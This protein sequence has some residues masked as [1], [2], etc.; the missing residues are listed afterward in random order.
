MEWRI[1]PR[2]QEV[3]AALLV[4][5]CVLRQPGSVLCARLGVELSLIQPV[6]MLGV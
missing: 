1:A 4:G 3:I 6:L 5:R 2:A